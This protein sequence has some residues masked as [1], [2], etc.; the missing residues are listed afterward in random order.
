[1]SSSI[2]N[3]IFTLGRKSTTYSANGLDTEW[4]R[5]D[6]A[7]A[8]RSGADAI[9]IPKI[10]SA[11]MVEQAVGAMRH[12]GAPGSMALWCMIETPK[13]V[14]AAA[15]I[16]ASSPR[17]ACLVMGTNDLVKDIRASHTPMRLP[18]I[19]ALGIALLAARAHGIAILDGVYNDFR[20]ADGFRASCVQGLELG[21]DGKTLIHPTQI[22]P[23]NE[24]FS[25]AAADLEDARKIVAAFAAVAA[26]GRAVV[27][28][29]GRMVENLH[30][31]QAKRMLNMA[32]AIDEMAGLAEVTGG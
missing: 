27:V 19:T 22:G 17:V 32:V 4:G 8:A 2:T 12:A 14:L 3:S 20:D 24:V 15:E 18:M 26:E 5:D 28:V 31:E 25:P 6:L 11:A 10:E 1:M 23:C 30:V 13:G 9:L 21:F 29:D 16:A 7:A